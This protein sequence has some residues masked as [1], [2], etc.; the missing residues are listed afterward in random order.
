MENDK[1]FIAQNKLAFR[2]PRWDVNNEYDNFSLVEENRD[3]FCG[4]DYVT[5]HF[6]LSS[7]SLSKLVSTSVFVSLFGTILRGPSEWLSC[8]DKF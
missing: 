4:T 8:G 5:A 1:G 3:F 2:H 7:T 6:L